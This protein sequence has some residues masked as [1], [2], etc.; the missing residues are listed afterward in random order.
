MNRIELPRGRYSL[1]RDRD[2]AGDS[3]PMLMTFDWDQRKDCEQGVIEVGKGVKCGSLYA[4]SYSGQ[5]WWLTTPVT[6]IIDAIRVY[7]E[8]SK[9]WEDHI[10]FKTGNSL[11]TLKCF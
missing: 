3:G 4:R 8:E 7:N 10:R 11:Y 6:E 5:D 9:E 1:R 2:G